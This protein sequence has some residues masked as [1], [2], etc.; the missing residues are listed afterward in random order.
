MCAHELVLGKTIDFITGETLVDTI[1]ERAR[2][3]IARY[4][5]EEKGYLK[6]DIE[7]RREIALTVDGNKGI[8]RVD[9]VIW[10]AG[11]AFMIIVFGPGSL[12]SRER[13]TVAAARLIASYEVPFA[14]VTNGQ[15]A[16]VLET[17]SGKV[18]AE[19]LENIPSKA[20]ALRKLETRTFERLSEKRLEKEKRILYAF[21]VLAKCE[22]DEF[23]CN[24]Y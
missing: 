1:D 14:V 10:I 19:G 13:S 16:E 2:Q 22:C 5:V 15:A 20:E 21:D 7:V 11:K 12:V 23:T 4:L 6:S 17:R 3:K 9:F 8:A 18:I 24:L